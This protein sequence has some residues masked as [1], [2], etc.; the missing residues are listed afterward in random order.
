MPCMRAFVLMRSVWE[1]YIVVLLPF[2]LVTAWPK[3]DVLLVVVAFI[4]FSMVPIF[5]EGEEL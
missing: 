1:R 5:R 2:Y 3:K 4:L